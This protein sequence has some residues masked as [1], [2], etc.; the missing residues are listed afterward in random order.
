M[1]DHALYLGEN[2][3]IRPGV[4]LQHW[5]ELLQDRYRQQATGAPGTF[6]FNTFLRRA[7]LFFEGSL[8]KKLSYMLA[9]EGTN[10]GRASTDPL[11]GTVIKRGFPD[12]QPPETP[13]SNFGVLFQDAFLSLD[14]HPAFSIQA[15]LMLLPF[16]RQTLQS[17]AT[18]IS[19]DT[20]TTS[21]TFISATRTSNLRDAGI[22]LKG[23]ILDH[24]EYRVGVFQGIRQ[25]PTVTPEQGSKNMPRLTGYLQYDFLD[26]EVGY[27]FN[28]QYF[29]HKNVLGVGAGFDYQKNIGATAAYWATS[30]TAFGS[31]RLNGDATS[32]GDTVDGLVQFLHFD[33]G[34]TLSPAALIPG[35]V[36]RQNAVGA[37]LG[38]YNKWLRFSFFGKLELRMITD[39]ALQE[40]NLRIYGGGVKY[41]IAESSAN[42]TFAFNRI[43]TPDANPTTSNP[44]VQ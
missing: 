12:T 27:T 2:F 17:T 44:G 21:A 34:K 33:P 39:A 1:R 36:P 25:G 19:L 5:T 26:S 10:L 40:A 22:E 15:G 42:L 30:A 3:S 6:E 31:V 11:D 29:G 4:Q 24:L 41:F 35:G 38:Y 13:F 23:I 9:L 7:R 43:E 20:L 14:L 8:F 32:G 18:C 28:G 16:A 37:E